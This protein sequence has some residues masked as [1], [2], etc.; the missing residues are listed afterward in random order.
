MPFNPITILLV[1]N[2][3]LA[4]ISFQNKFINLS[5]L[6][7]SILRNVYRSVELIFILYFSVYDIGSLDNRIRH[8]QTQV[9]VHVF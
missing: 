9:R 6:K 1:R 5:R 4:C 7:E 8:G 2:N 3:M